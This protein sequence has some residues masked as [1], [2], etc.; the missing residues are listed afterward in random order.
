M[1]PSRSC[2]RSSTRAGAQRNTAEPDA[3]QDAD[4]VAQLTH[5]DVVDILNA[6]E[7]DLRA[8]Y[9]TNPRILNELLTQFADGIEECKAGQRD[10]ATLLRA[11]LRGEW[12]VFNAWNEHHMNHPEELAETWGQIDEEIESFPLRLAVVQ[13]GLSSLAEERPPIH[14]FATNSEPTTPQHSSK[15]K[16]KAPADEDFVSTTMKKK[17]GGRSCETYDK[18]ADAPPASL[19]FP[20]GNILLAEVVTFVPHSLKSLDFLDRGLGNGMRQLI[21]AKIINHH[22]TMAR[23]KIDKNSVYRTF[24]GA[25]DKR[26]KLHPDHDPSWKD[27]KTGIHNQYHNATNFDATSVSVAGFRPGADGENTT[28]HSPMPFADLAVGVKA[29]PSGNNALDLTRM[30]EYCRDHPEEIWMYPVDW[31]RL[32]TRIGGPAQV[33]PA[34]HDAAL[35]ARWTS[36]RQAANTRKTTSRKRDGRG[37][38]LK[39]DNSEDEMNF[40]EMDETDSEG[41]SDGERDFDQL[42]KKS[43]RKGTYADNS[44]SDAYD[45]PSR[46]P[47]AKRPKIAPKPRL[48]Q[49]GPSRLRKELS[50]SDVDSESGSDGYKGPKRFKKMKTAPPTRRSGRATKINVS[51]TVDEPDY[52]D[53]IPDFEETSEKPDLLQRYGMHANKRAKKSNDDKAMEDGSN[54]G[55]GEDDEEED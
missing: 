16:G 51:Y 24:K 13:R 47:K 20:N 31:D 21:I 46:K 17:K 2:T 53:E 45:S 8:Q 36:S 43:K 48:G 33:V 34:M 50:V 28:T 52:N 30:V 42:D 29:F 55:S 10:P 4:V 3:Q 19:G 22:R 32:L 11:R 1:E 44:D 27:W 12:L 15:S 14:P 37:R 40:E 38:L 7:V 5:V 9:D 25:M 18:L 26:A 49:R 39:K 35:L 6:A 54:V 41:G 23:G